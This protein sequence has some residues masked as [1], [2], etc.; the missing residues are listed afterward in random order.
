VPLHVIGVMA[1]AVLAVSAA[2]P[3]V[4]LAEGVHPVAIGAW[5]TLG[6]ALILAPAFKPLTRRD[7]ALTGLAGVLLALHFWSWFASLGHTTVMRSTL[8]VTLNPVWT[9]LVEWLAW[10]ESPRPVYWI[11]L[12]VAAPGVLLLA[13]GGVGGEATLLGDGLALLGGVFGSLYLLVGRRVRQRVGI[14]TYGG[15]VS[16][17]AAAVLLPLALVLEAPLVG[18]P[19]GSWLALL[20]L[21]VGPQLL[22]HV[23]FNYSV[24]YVKAS[25]AAAFILLEPVGAALLAVALFAEVPGGLEVAGGVLVLVGVLVATRPGREPSQVEVP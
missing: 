19:T 2:A 1:V 5:R 15:L 20:G 10:R 6:V 11:G 7:T 12:G 16:A 17:A 25:V 21:T 4:R 8:L 13:G 18:Y 9:A 22:G 3:L 14:A 23:G 24:R